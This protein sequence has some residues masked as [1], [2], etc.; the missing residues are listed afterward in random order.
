[1][2]Y[3]S[4]HHSLVAWPELVFEDI[5]DVDRSQWSKLLTFAQGRLM[6]ERCGLDD[7]VGH[8][9]HSHQAAPDFA[10]V[11]AKHLFFNIPEGNG[12]FAREG[13][14]ASVQIV[15]VRDQHHLAE[16]VEQSG[17]ERLRS[18]GSIIGLE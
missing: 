13:V 5:S 2:Y 17:R 6:V 9:P 1:M 12:L 14:N 18:Q 8:I 7:G 11:R 3:G 4:H 15:K 16:V 10:M